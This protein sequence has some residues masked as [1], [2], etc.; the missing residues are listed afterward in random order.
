MG[1]LGVQGKR[2]NPA[3]EGWE[4]CLEEER[5]DLSPGAI[6][7]GTGQ[8]G[9]FGVVVGLSLHISDL[10]MGKSREKHRQRKAAHPV[11]SEGCS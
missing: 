2:S 7:S 1:A 5:P 8:G 9:K 4:A 3:W 11:V 6:T 10:G